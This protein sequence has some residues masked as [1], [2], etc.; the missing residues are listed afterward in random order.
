MIQN[1]K[2]DKRIDNK[3]NQKKEQ[4]DKDNAELARR[5]RHKM[6]EKSALLT[7]KIIQS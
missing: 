7:A 5:F 6:E 4:S 2:D 3:T 1:R